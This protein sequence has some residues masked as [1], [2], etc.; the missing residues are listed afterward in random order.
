MF[1]DKKQIEQHKKAAKALN[2]IIKK[3]VEFIKHNPK[4]TDVEVR[5]FI[6]AQYKKYRLISDKQKSIVAFGDDTSNVHFYAEEPRELK[7]GDLIMIDIWARLAEIG[8][9][10]ADITWMMYYGVKA[11]K[12]YINT[13]K[14]VAQARDKAINFLKN[15]L[16]KKVVPTGKEV[17]AIVRNYLAKHGHGDKFL[18]GTGHSLGFVSPHGTRTRISKKGKQPLPLNVGYTIEPGIYFKNKFGVRSEIDFYID[19]NFKIIITT[20]VQNK[21]INI[22]PVK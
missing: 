15:N 5:Q 6:K 3:I 22:H 13:F 9:P 12:Q 11:P 19:K 21:I 17:D 14:I 18:H 4:T 8:A 1:L 10:F 20:K 2:K 7:N 16:R